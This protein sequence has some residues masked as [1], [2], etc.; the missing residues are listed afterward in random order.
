MRFA[1]VFGHNVTSTLVNILLL[2]NDSDSF[3]TT[4]RIWFQDVHVL[5]VTGLSIRHPA[6]VILRKD[7]RWRGNVERL[8]MQTSHALHVTPH[9]VF[10]TDGPRTCEMVDV[11]LVAHVAKSPLSK[12]PSPYHIPPCARYM[13]ETGHFESVDY[14]II[15]VSAL[16]NF[17]TWGAVGF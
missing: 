15:G 17:E 5:E 13:T 6:L 1:H 4:C 3:A 8:T 7:V 16:R 10:A 14:T 2:A 12:E 9:I 11:L